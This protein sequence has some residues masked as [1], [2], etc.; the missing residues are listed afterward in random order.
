MI[1]KTEKTKKNKV[2][3]FG[4]GTYSSVIAEEPRITPAAEGEQG[5]VGDSEA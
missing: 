2:P 4:L 1:I 5:T 3:K